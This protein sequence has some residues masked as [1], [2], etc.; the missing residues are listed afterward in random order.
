L[1]HRLLDTFFE[2]IGLCPKFPIGKL[3]VFR[4]Q[5]VD[6]INERLNSLDLPL[7]F[8]ADDSFEK[9]HDHFN[10]PEHVQFKIQNRDRRYKILPRLG[11]ALK[12]DHFQRNREFRQL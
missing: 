5:G 2:I 11:K 1:S 9:T 10:K 4:L 3:L 6:L 7:I 12:T 8:C